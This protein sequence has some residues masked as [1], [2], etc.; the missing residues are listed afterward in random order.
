MQ[1]TAYKRLMKSY[2]INLVN[3]RFGGIII[4]SLILTSCVSIRED[5]LRLNDKIINI[6]TYTKGI[7]RSIQEK[8]NEDVASIRKNQAKM[9]AEIYQIR[10]EMRALNGLVEENQLLI[11]STIKRTIPDIVPL[12]K[13]VSDQAEQLVN[14]WNRIAQLQ[15]HLSLKQDDVFGQNLA[16]KAGDRK[17]QQIALLPSETSQKG[18]QPDEKIYTKILSIYKD[19]QYDEAIKE[20]NTFIKQYPKSGLIDNAQFW[21]GES[22]LNQKKY[23]QAILAFQ[24]VIQKYPEGNKVPNSMLSQSIAFKQI[25]DTISAKLLLKKVIKQY[26]NSD[27]AGI[28]KV[29]L[30]GFK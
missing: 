4:L 29:K 3:I 15:Q 7:Q 26:P 28:A 17:N 18:K 11:K 14:L 20:F 27:E 22:L 5:I 23:E 1:V 2:L 12:K 25:K 19:K 10:E 30:K 24:E 16:E 6:D 13:Q 8:T 21:I 9:G